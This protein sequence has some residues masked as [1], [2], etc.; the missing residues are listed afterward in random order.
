MRSFARAV[1]CYAYYRGG[2][3]DEHMRRGIALEVAGDLMDLFS[4]RNWRTFERTVDVSLWGLESV[5]LKAVADGDAI[6]TLDTATAATKWV[7]QD[8]ILSDEPY[9]ITGLNTATSI[10]IDPAYD[11]SAI[12]AGTKVDIRQLRI[13]LP[14][15]FGA[16]LGPVLRGDDDSLL[17]DQEDIVRASRSATI[18]SA[19]VHAIVGKNLMIWPPE[20]GRLFF[21]YRYRPDSPYYYLDGSATVK[22]ANLKRALGTGTKWK[23]LPDSASGTVLEEQDNIDRGMPLSTEVLL[24]VDDTTL[25]LKSDWVGTLDKSF[26]YLVSTDL[27]L[28]HYLSR[29]V[30]ARA[31]YLA[32]K[33]TLEEVSLAFFDAKEADDASDEK[34]LAAAGYGFGGPVQ[35][36]SWWE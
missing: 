34:D 31:R 16:L 6:L 9:L 29:W 4:K 12:A 5:A 7:G 21:R 28:P 30:Q 35:G 33:G 8:V 26:K 19:E 10:R 27:S 14:T 18:G 24:T 22:T 36:V 15:G 3:S 32:R 20:S 13:G 1:H 17:I 2:S 25:A 23:Q 11:G